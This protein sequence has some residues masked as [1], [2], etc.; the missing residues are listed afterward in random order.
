M[1]IISWIIGSKMGRQLAVA[2][3]AIM[4]FGAALLK[5]FK[6]GE[7]KQKADEVKRGLEVVKDKVKTDEEIRSMS[8]DD[9]RKRLREWATPGK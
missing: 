3:L 9:R 2:L 5:A 1:T 8:M 6:A 4:A 7:S